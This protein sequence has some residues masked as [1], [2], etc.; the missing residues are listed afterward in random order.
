MGN[1]L[2]Q[3]LIEARNFVGVWS[4]VAVLMPASETSVIG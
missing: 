4:T 2:C 3:I 1:L